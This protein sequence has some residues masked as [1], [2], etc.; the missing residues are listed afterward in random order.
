MFFINYNDPWYFFE[1]IPFVLIGIFGGL[2]GALFI[3]ANI[4]WCRIRKTT[5]LGR[6][7]Y[8]LVVQFQY[9]SKDYHIIII[10]FDYVK[11]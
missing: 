2:W 11:F 8:F 9:I 4:Y 5:V 6:P 1:L 7:R 3:K 10:Q